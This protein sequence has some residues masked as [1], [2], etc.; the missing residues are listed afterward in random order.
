MEVR[1]RGDLSLRIFLFV[2]CPGLPLSLFFSSFEMSM[3]ASDIF[4]ILLLFVPLA[5]AANLNGKFNV[6]RPVAGKHECPLGQA[7]I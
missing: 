2:V 6:P 4:S 1:A 5:L 3:G 7:S